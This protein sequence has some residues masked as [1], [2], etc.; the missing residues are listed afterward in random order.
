MQGYDAA[1]AGYDRS[2]YQ[3][4]LGHIPMFAKCNEEQ[5]DHLAQLGTALAV[6]DGHEIVREGERG[7]DFYVLTSGKARVTRNAREV[8]SIGAGEYFG[9]LA[10]FDPA[11]RNA[12]VTADGE[13]SLVVLSRDAFRQA[14]D[15]VPAMRDALLHGM[16]HRLHELDSTR[17]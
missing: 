11:P 15:E 17:R 3:A 16:A 14:L 9:E 6:E 12:T 5:L 10:L 1:M 7:D 4:Y 2:L 13:V 8:A